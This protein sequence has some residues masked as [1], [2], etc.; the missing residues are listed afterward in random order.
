LSAYA[1][2]RVEFKQATHNQ[3]DTHRKCVGA[4]DNEWSEA[5]KLAYNTDNMQDTATRICSLNKMNI[6]EN[7]FKAAF[8]CPLLSAIMMHARHQQL[9]HRC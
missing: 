5:E 3:I 8:E 2:F 4:K 7:G 6:E 1:L 9:W